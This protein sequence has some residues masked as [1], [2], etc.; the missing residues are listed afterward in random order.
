VVEVCG[1]LVQLDVQAVLNQL[2]LGA[3][4]GLLLL[5]EVEG[6]DLAG[7]D[8]VFEED[9]GEIGHGESAEGALDPQGVILGAAEGFVVAECGGI[10]GAF[11]Q[12]DG[13]MGEGI[14]EEEGGRDFGGFGGK[15]CDGGDGCGVVGK[16][17]NE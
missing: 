12:H 6:A 17:L 14:A 4:D 8:A 9:L 13:G 2:G 11:A 10:E 7:M 3:R 16:L 15:A 1:S 5:G